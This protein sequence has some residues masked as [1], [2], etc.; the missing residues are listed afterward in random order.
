LPSF[1]TKINNR[2]RTF[3]ALVSTIE[4]QLREAYDRKHRNGTITQAE[5]AAKL[6]VNRSVVNRRLT[7]R[8]NMTIETLADMVW[9]LDQQVYVA[10]FD[11][12]GL[13]GLNHPHQLQTLPLPAKTQ[14]ASQSGTLPAGL[15]EALHGKAAPIPSLV[16]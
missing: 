16:R 15:I 4:R 2:R 12:T 8:T 14:P 11:P 9:A 13:P 6:G 1:R 5:L 7:G 10:I 3:L